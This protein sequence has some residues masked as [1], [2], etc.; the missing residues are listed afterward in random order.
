MFR[1]LALAGLAAAGLLLVG[2]ASADNKLAK[3]ARSPDDLYH[4]HAEDQSDRI[5]LA[6][7]AD[8]L[9]AAQQDAL[10]ALAGRWRE[11]GAR[12]IQISAPHGLVDS[13]AAYKSAQAARDK[14]IALGVPAEAIN[15]VSYDAGEDPKAPLLVEFTRFEAVVAACGRSWENLTATE[16]NTVQSNFGCA[17]TANMAAQIADPADIAGPRAGASADAGRRVTIIEGYRK[18]QITSAATDS[19]SSGAVSSAVP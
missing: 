12:A 7:H 6:V 15:Q 17:V 16:A 5:M 1:T 4:L 9:S 18:G 3:E 13:V 2:C 8:G 19:K 11:G 14:L 10:T